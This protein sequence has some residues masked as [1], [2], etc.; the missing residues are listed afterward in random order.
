MEDASETSSTNEHGIF[1]L[2]VHDTI[3]NEHFL[4]DTGADV[5]VLPLATSTYQLRP[6]EIQLF[7]ANGTPIKVAGERVIKLNLGLRREFIW[8]FIVADV[9]TPI[10]GAD[11]IRHHD[12]LIDLRRNRLIDNETKV[13]STCIRIDG[14][15]TVN[16]KTFDTTNPYA[17]LLAEFADI[18]KL[19][20]YGTRTG[21]T[22]YHHIET[23]GQP[24]FARPRRLA[25][26]R[27]KA[28]RDE[29]EFLMRAGIC[30]PSKS[31]WSSPLH[32]VR[33]SNGTWRPCGDY[34]ALNA[35]TKPDRYPLPYLNDFTSNL[36]GKTVFTKIDLQKA[37]HQVP[38]HPDD[39]DKTAII[40]PFG[41]YEFLFMTFGLCN[42]AQTFQ[43]L[44]H[45]VLRGLD[46]VF[47]YI[48]D[49][50]IASRTAAEHRQHLRL[51]FQRLRENHLAIN[52]AKC[53]FGKTQLTF[54]GH[55]LTK[56]G[57][58]PEKVDAISNF[59]KPTIAKELKSFLAMINFYR[60]FLPHATTPQ[61][62]LQAMIVGNKR[63]DRTPLEWSADTESAF[64]QCKK[65]LADTTLLAHPSATAELALFSD[66]SDTA[67]GAALHQ[68]IDGE[69]QPLAFYS[70]KLTDTQQKYSTYDRE[71]TAMFQG[72]RHF[73]Y[74][75]EGRRCFIVTDHKP[76]TFA[77][78][79]NLEKATPRQARQL[80]IIGQFTTDI[81]H[82]A[83]AANVTAD[84]L[85][86]IQTIERNIDYNRMAESQQNDAEIQRLLNNANDGETSVELKSFVTP[87]GKAQ[88]FCDI[89]KGRIRPYVTTPFRI[90]VMANTHGLSH[91]GVRATSKMIAERFV[92][93]GMRKDIAN[94]VRNCIACQRSKVH[95]H[96][97]TT[98]NKYEAP[99]HRFAHINIDIVGPYPPCEGQQYCL[100]II[101]RFTRWPEALPM[102][103]KTA[104]T[105]A[106]TICSGWIARFGVPSTI[107]SDRGRQFECAVFTELMTLTGTNHWKT[108]AYHPQSNGIIERWH[109]SLKS[110]ILCRE[111]SRWTHNLPSILLG[112]RVAY[113]PDI[114]ATPAE[115]VY[116]TTL[117][118][119][120]EFFD[121][122]MPTTIDS[123][124]VNKFRETMR[125]LRPTNTAHHATQKT[126]KS[127]QLASTTHVFVRDDSVRQSLTHPY[128]GPFKVIKRS[129]KFFTISIR[130]RHTNVSIDRLKPAFTTSDEMETADQPPQTTSEKQHT[131]TADTTNENA[132]QMENSSTK[133]T[134]A[135]RKITLPVRFK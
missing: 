99:T 32:M 131:N 13:E 127:K 74:M 67:V 60:K 5:C 76:L 102:P 106:R 82:I 98:P 110:A 40:T 79:Q 54:L 77:Y 128:N 42:A 68:L 122:S 112:L 55:L 115:L 130:G 134:R 59:P 120:G 66:A 9:S 85:S 30:R 124:A 15:D 24:V 97:K 7:A 104:E 83:G 58:R 28:A 8:P 3:H 114:N 14:T 96:T 11:F 57:M 62:K 87:D 46:F 133:T 35:I 52:L 129:D 27:Y 73:R 111:S 23:T 75:L 17:D 49:L 4:V 53:E 41:L 108:T 84:L 118:I 65:Q 1:R 93:Y 123:E 34:R 90:Q 105:V 100:T 45:E 64:E 95:R 6:T 107:T 126:F 37:F 103:D 92:W 125:N 18:T 72:V 70:K 33:K 101:D 81:R 50:C 132:Q 36:K 2:R 20:P 71:L 89:S 113:K 88:L 38:I 86:R 117:K 22:V 121:D 135:G 19:T 47:P 12:I 21:S 48:D 91:P 116:G 56:D 31:N 51:V 10:I 26:E 109:R 43:R 25:P 63:N 29:F 94:F 80:D 78:N 16:I 39:I 119:P 69:F 61:A 44:I